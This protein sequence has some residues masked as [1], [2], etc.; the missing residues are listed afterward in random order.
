MVAYQTNQ[1]GE[2]LDRVRLWLTGENGQLQTFPKGQ[3]FAEDLSVPSRTIVISELPPNYRLE[4]VIPNR[5]HFFE[6]PLPREL[7]IAMVRH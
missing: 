5:D 2:R 6:E 3:A 1:S 4:F 7:F